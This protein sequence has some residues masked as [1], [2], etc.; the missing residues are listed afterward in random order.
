MSRLYQYVG[1]NDIRLA[2]AKFPAGTKIESVSQLE[3][4]I[5]KNSKKPKDCCS[6]A[7][8]FVVDLKGHLCIADRHSEHIAC[9][10]TNSVLS[11]GEIFF[12]GRNRG[13]EVVE[14]TNQSTGFCPEPE[15]WPQVAIALDRIPIPHPNKF[16]IEFVFRRCPVCDQLN[17]IKDNLLICSVCNSDLPDVWNCNR[18]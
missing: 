7:A 12:E 15:S 8:T 9:A 4:W 3:N 16:T 1:S 6:I 11:A 13:W 5:A 18:C 14:I 2:V 17:I 10:G